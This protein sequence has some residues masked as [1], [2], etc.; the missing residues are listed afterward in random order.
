M[1][2]FAKKPTFFDCLKSTCVESPNIAFNR[3]LDF[4]SDFCNQLSSCSKTKTPASM[5]RVLTYAKAIN[6][7]IGL[8]QNV[9]DQLFHSS[10][11]ATLRTTLNEPKWEDV[12][13]GAPLKTSDDTIIL[14][15]HEEWCWSTPWIPMSVS[16]TTKPQIIFVPMPGV[17]TMQSSENNKELGPN[18]HLSL[19]KRGQQTLFRQKNR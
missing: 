19:K 1:S 11:Y 18:Q 15:P 10:A 4:D 3:T 2:S 13:T 8:D 6:R 12:V 5:C 16:W 9:L 7:F 14:S 17:V